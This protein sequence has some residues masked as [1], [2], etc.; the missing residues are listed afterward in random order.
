MQKS[1]LIATPEENWIEIDSN[2]HNE[3]RLN[4]LMDIKNYK[5]TWEFLR[6]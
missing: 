4:N 1:G 6:K 5:R 3:V 2:T